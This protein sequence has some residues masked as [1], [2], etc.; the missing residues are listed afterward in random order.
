MNE[1]TVKEYKVW[2]VPTRIFHWLNFLTVISLI[3]VACPVLK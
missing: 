2:D 3:F 1:L